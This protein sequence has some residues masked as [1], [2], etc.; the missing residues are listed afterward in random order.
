MIRN[1]YTSLGADQVDIPNLVSSNLEIGDSNSNISFKAHQF[2][3][4]G[5]A[6]NNWF[7]IARLGTDNTNSTAQNRGVAVIEIYNRQS[8]RHQCVRMFVSQIFDSG[9]SIGRLQ[10]WVQHWWYTISSSSDC[11]GCY[12]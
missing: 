6:N 9:G 10:C 2:T 1:S 7:T 11:N 12:I 3:L 4:S 5:V 8:V